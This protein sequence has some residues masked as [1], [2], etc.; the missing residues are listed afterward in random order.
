MSAATSEQWKTT[1]CKCVKGTLEE[2]QIK[3]WVTSLDLFTDALYAIADIDVKGHYEKEK[4]N[5]TSSRLIHM[6]HTHTH[7]HAEPNHLIPS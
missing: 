1:S 5:V 4:K 7:T 6:P 3:S 2:I